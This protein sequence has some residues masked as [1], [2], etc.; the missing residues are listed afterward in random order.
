[1]E[2]NVLVADGDALDMS[3]GQ[4]M[5]DCIVVTSVFSPMEYYR[6]VMSDNSAIDSAGQLY[7]RISQIWHITSGTIQA[8]QYDLA[9]D[10]FL[11]LGTRKNPLADYLNELAP[12]E[13]A[14]HPDPL[15][16]LGKIADE[17]DPAKRQM[18]L[19]P[20]DGTQPSKAS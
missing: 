6:A 4:A 15:D 10:R 12:T 14:K 2:L 18:P 9:S 17:Y 16:M 13:N 5:A 8:S 3:D 19:F 11:S 7:R 20:P 1:M